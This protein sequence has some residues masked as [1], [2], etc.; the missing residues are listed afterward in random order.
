M[1][2][3]GTADGKPARIF[4]SDVAVMLAGSNDWVNAQINNGQA[5]LCT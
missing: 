2:H 4:F 3:R 1:D 5:Q